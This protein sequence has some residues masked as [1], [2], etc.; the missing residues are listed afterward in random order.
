MLMMWGLN[1]RSGT[2]VI[3]PG[4]MKNLGALKLISGHLNKITRITLA[5]GA[6]M[7]KNSLDNTAIGL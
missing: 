6:M 2:K 7:S 3:I 5:S 4:I 1:L